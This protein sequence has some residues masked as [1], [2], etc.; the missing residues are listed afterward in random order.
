MLALAAYRDFSR[1]VEKALRRS[2]NALATLIESGAG[3]SDL[4]TVAVLC[5]G[6]RRGRR[7]QR[8][9]GAVVIHIDRRRALISTVGLAVGGI[10]TARLLPEEILLRDRRAGPIPSRDRVNWVL[11]LLGLSDSLLRVL[12]PFGLILRGKS[13]LLKPNLVE[14]IVGVEVNTNPIFVAAAAEAFRSLGARSVVVAEG[15]GHQSDTY[16]VLAERGLEA[17]LC[18]RTGGPA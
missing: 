6:S 5:V 14:Y 13:V 10:A 2:T 3:A 9:R 1:E 15:P 12:R 16:L 7:R 11:L 8:V 17:Q 4:C 18:I